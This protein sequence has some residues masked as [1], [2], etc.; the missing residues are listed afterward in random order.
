MDVT[1]DV[2]YRHA[3]GRPATTWALMNDAARSTRSGPSALVGSHAR[4]EATS[5]TRAGQ[6]RTASVVNY[7]VGDHGTFDYT[8]SGV[9]ACYRSILEMSSRGWPGGLRWLH[10]EDES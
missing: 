9:N 10:G 1:T 3:D 5:Y 4:D 6:F 7:F 8:V 2:V